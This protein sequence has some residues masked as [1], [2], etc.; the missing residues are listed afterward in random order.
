MVLRFISMLTVAVFCC[1]NAVWAD[2][3]DIVASKD[4]TLI[5]SVSGDKANGSGEWLFVG[6]TDNKGIR[7]ALVAFDVAASIPFGATITAVELKMFMSKTITGTATIDLHRVTVD[8]GEGGSNPVGDEGGG[9][10]PAAGDSTWI[11]SFFPGI[12]WAS[13]GGDFEAG[14]S[15]SA[16]VGSFGSYTWQSTAQMVQDVQ[17]WLDGSGPNFGWLLKGPEESTSAKRFDSRS[18]GTDAEP[19]LS[20]TFTPPRV[21]GQPAGAINATVSPE[22]VVQLVLNITNTEGVDPDDITQEWLVITAQIGGV[23][24]GV[25]LLT[26]G[27]QL[28]PVNATTDFSAATFSFNHAAGETFSLATLS[29]GALGMIA[30]DFLAYAYGYTT[31]D[32]GDLV[33][34]NI[35]TVVVED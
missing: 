11:H 22:E 33:L 34:N 19:V 10:A 28:V 5:E 6:K 16:E 25:F 27:G 14:A 32:I 18:A 21:I 35:V 29:L 15:G 7:R 3:V 8:W 30:G 2:T 12:L 26:S 23:P 4:A 24:A 9:V 31:S 1:G 13:S 17:D 20:V